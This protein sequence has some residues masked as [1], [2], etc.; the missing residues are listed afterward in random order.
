MPCHKRRFQKI[1]AIY[2]L[3]VTVQEFAPRHHKLQSDPIE[4]QGITMP[5]KFTPSGSAGHTDKEAFP[6]EN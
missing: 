3:M 6:N 4:I 1:S 5:I 2:S